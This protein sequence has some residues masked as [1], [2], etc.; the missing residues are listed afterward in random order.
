M[1]FLCTLLSA[2]NLPQKSI[3][4]FAI[5]NR[6]MAECPLTS[7]ER[8]WM[9][10]LPMFFD[11][12]FHFY[13]YALRDKSANVFL[14]ENWP[15]VMEQLHDGDYVLIGFY[16]D[17]LTNSRD[18]HSF[19]KALTRFI[20]DIRARKAVP[21]LVTPVTKQK[22]SE[23]GKAA[24]LVKEVAA[25]SHVSSIDLQAS[26]LPLFG[27]QQCPETE[28]LSIHE[29]I[30]VANVAAGLL[31]RLIPDFNSS[32]QH[33]VKAY[34]PPKVY[35][36]RAADNIAAGLRYEAALDFNLR[37][38]PATKSSWDIYRKELVN[39]ILHASRTAIDHHL[40]LD[41][42]ETGTIQRK[43]Y[44]I[45]KIY[46]QTRPGVYATAN[47]YVPDGKGPF[48]A[49]IN[50]HGH[51]PDGKAGEMVQSCAH[52]L[53]LNGYVCLNI[54]AWGAG[55]RTTVHGEQEYHGSNLGASLMNIGETLLGNQLSDNI[56]GVDLLC[57]LP[58]VDKNRIGATGASGGG[59][60][61]MWV[62]AIDDR[63]KASMPVVSVGSFQ[64]YILG[65]NCVCELLPKGLTFT[66]ESGVL[67][68]IAPRAIKICNGLQDA[69]K[70]FNPAEMIRSYTNA[71]PVFDLYHESDHIQYQL[72]NT[73]HGYWPEIRQAML[74][75]FDLQLKGEGDGGFKEEKPFTLLPADELMVFPKGKRDPLVVSTAVYCRRKGEKLTEAL[76]QQEHI[77][78]E[79]KLKGLARILSLPARPNKIKGIHRYGLKDQWQR[80][81]LEMSNGHL[82]PISSHPAGIDHAPV[83]II[84]PSDSRNKE[85]LD[86]VIKE[87]IQKGYGIVLAEV[88]G[89]GENTS[90]EAR[91]TDGS[92]PEFHTLSRSE[93][94]LGH[95][96]MGE[97]VNNINGIID[98]VRSD[99]K[100]ASVTID[101]DKEVAVAS[102]LESALHNN[103]DTCVLRTCPVSYVFDQREHVDFFNM[104]IHIPGILVWG[105]ISLAAALN[106][107]A[108]LIFKNPVSISGREIT[109]KESSDLKIKFAKMQSACDTQASIVFTHQ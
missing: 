108:S 90:P 19:N 74:G 93:L 61:T 24:S 47:L 99:Y 98:F 70:T 53:A 25:R 88:W 14:Q 104:A 97:W 59:N 11:L 84:L 6:S 1:L 78:K 52:E 101:A 32:G 54:D 94:W 41:C 39:K 26:A 58:Y 105:D 72:F 4:V 9:Q 103:A 30:G 87:Y 23:N 3:R 21:V 15:S 100:P 91:T 35:G 10:M 55:E 43:G 92:L 28:A 56:R 67:A 89:T 44:A 20:R 77:N 36:D 102:L 76:Y 17:S 42:H 106:D 50:M 16:S 57:S 68:L 2:F 46:F 81:V 40:P 18:Q 34:L 107:K 86:K 85:S 27:D 62:S 5:G 51:W 8:G 12:N 7:A 83:V 109:G 71:K 33:D 29:A 95:T 48:P 65:S 69:N 60:Q 37:Q 96:I 22:N 82:I 31:R 73:P 38:L 80:T 49:V 75:W 13:N 45:K 64:S 66:E 79:Q 63:I